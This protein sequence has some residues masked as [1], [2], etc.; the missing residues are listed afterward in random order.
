VGAGA[1]TVALLSHVWPRFRLRVQGLTDEEHL[2]EPVEGC[3]SVRAGVV[4]GGPVSG[5]HAPVTTIAW[6]LWHLGSSTLDGFSRR[7]FGRPVLPFE[8]HDLVWF[9]GAEPSLAALDRAWGGFSQEVG[10]LDEAAFAAPLGPDFGPLA[11][12]S[13]ADAILH[14]TD[15]IIHHAAEVALLRDLYAAG[16]RD[17]RR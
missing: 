12:A 8:H 4:D 9:D 10:Q 5:S 1:S 14:V 17:L 11:E 16:A 13:R 7:L 15:E 6:R 3:W 2:W